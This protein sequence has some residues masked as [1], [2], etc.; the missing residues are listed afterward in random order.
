MT[1]TQNC[2][3]RFLNRMRSELKSLKLEKETF[4]IFYDA[5]ESIRG[6]VDNGLIIRRKYLCKYLYVSYVLMGMYQVS[7]EIKRTLMI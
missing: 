5:N 7:S 3:L 2:I 6:P 1:R 4:Y